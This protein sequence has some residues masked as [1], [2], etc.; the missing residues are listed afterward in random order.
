MLGGRCDQSRPGPPGVRDE[1]LAPGRGASSAGGTRRGP[2]ALPGT[3]GALDVPPRGRPDTNAECRSS[4]GQCASSVTPNPDTPIVAYGWWYARTGII[5]SS[6]GRTRPVPV[7]PAVGL[8]ALSSVRSRQR[9]AWRRGSSIWR[10]GTASAPVPGPTLTAVPVIETG[11]DPRLMMT[12]YADGVAGRRA[13]GGADA[14]QPTRP[15]P[16]AG[17]QT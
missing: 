1:R 14:R 17:R 5:W 13:S 10:A 7:A 8:P 12:S 9:A 16:A 6:S 3:P 4:Q 11:I 2:A 15:F